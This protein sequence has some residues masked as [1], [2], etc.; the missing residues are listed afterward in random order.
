[1][2]IGYAWLAEFRGV[3]AP[4]PKYYAEVRPVTR[5]E[6]IG[7]CLAVPASVAP[8]TNCPLAHVLF[9]LK[10]EGVN[11]T[12]LAQALPLI[13]ESQLRQAYAD[14]PTSQYL[15]KACYL[16]EHF[17]QCQIQRE[18]KPPRAN[19]VELFDPAVYVTSHG[20]RD[21]RWRVVFNGLGTLEYCVSVR[22][23][24][25]LSNL[26]DKNLLQRAHEFT[27]QLPK[28]ILNRALA[29]AYLDE[30]RSSYAIEQE[31]PSADK[32]SRFV[33]LLKQAHVPRQLDE[34][35]LV[36]LQNA[37]VSNVYDQAASFRTEQNYLCNGL[38][39]ALGVSYVPPTPELCYHLM[40]QLMSIA[41]DPPAGI[42]PLVLATLISFGFVFLH[43][44]MDGN[45]RLSRFLFHQVLCQQGAL[46]HGLLLPVSIVL[47][48]Q[49]V[50][51]KAT[52]EA[53]SAQTRDYWQ[54]TYLD[55][56]QF[57]FE[58]QGHA[59]VYKY[60]DATECVIFMASAVE[61]AT[62]Q[63]LKQETQYLQ[64]YDELYRRM[65]QAFDV[66]QSELS[67]L[68]MFCLDQQ[69]KLSANRRKQYQYRVPEAL[70][71]ALEQAYLDV[72]STPPES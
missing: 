37:V 5:V 72:F 65:D 27:E 50:V 35:Y 12:I 43:P 62:E 46:R 48:Q 3:K 69:G 17:T 53:W 30:T 7:N 64:H 1:M 10:Y 8:T 67:K 47:R 16:W 44:F 26:L 71:D 41:N 24:A 23:T 28:D 4:T 66:A 61:Q 6:Q 15:R 32:T 25:T 56:E 20:I 21:M 34:D 40:Q 9:A 33:N 36:S 13:D 59:S 52:L 54:V 49:E 45:G 68:V 18:A 70:F 42:D 55:Q 60:W 57:V 39:G 58:F 63:H 14:S 51:Y 19:Y 2:R 29:W 31:L 11:L 22:K 38:R